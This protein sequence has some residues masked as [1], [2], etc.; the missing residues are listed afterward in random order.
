MNG[1]LKIDVPQ[2]IFLALSYIFAQNKPLFAYF[3]SIFLKVVLKINI[4]LSLSR[5]H[6]C[7]VVGSYKSRFRELVH[8]L[9]EPSHVVWFKNLEPPIDS[10]HAWFTL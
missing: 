10:D 8:P 5:C 1:L 3:S 2:F 6:V 9:F 7:T 4:R